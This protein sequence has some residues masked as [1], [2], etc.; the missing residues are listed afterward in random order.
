MDNA[1]K[2]AGE[3]VS[4]SPS[5]F[6]P[7]IRQWQRIWHPS[8]S[9]PKPMKIKDL[10]LY[11]PKEHEDLS[12]Y[13]FV[14]DDPLPLEQQF[15]S[16][17]L[18]VQE[19]LEE[20]KGKFSTAKGFVSSVQS[21]YKKSMEFIEQDS[22][23]IPKALAIVVGGMGGF[24]FGLRRGGVFKRVFYTGAGLG[25]VAAF[26]YPHETVDIARTGYLHGGDFVRRNWTEFTQSPTPPALPAAPAAEKSK[27]EVEEKKKKDADMYTTR[28]DK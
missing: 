14:E 25:I 22:S 10:P 23:S 28:S 17:R 8:A 7:V 18:A 27:K 12:Q 21:S 15:H 16:I 9:D 26:C 4:E 20:M 19:P 24:L 3:K 5:Y 2:K 13:Y 6:A 1:E 11:P